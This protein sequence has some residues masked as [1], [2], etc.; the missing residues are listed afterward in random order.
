MVFNSQ[1]VKSL[2]QLMY[3]VDRIYVSVD[4]DALDI[5]FACDVPADFWWFNGL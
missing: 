4:L 1:Y 3:E 2:R 5:V